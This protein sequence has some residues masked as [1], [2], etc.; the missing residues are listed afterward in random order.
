MDARAGKPAPRIVTSGDDPGLALT[1]TRTAGV[2]LR[3]RGVIEQSACETGCAASEQPI[4]VIDALAKKSAPRMAFPE[5]RLTSGAAPSV[6]FMAV[7]L[8]PPRHDHC[9]ARDSLARSVKKIRW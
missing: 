7:N 8:E 2:A 1:D 6:V 3:L 4:A 9:R 5:N